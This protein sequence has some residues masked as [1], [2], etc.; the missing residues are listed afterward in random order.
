MK[1]SSSPLSRYPVALRTKIFE[2]TKD[3]KFK[4]A[5]KPYYWTTSEDNR[6]IEFADAHGKPHAAQ[7]D[8]PKHSDLATIYRELQDDLMRTYDSIN[9][10]RVASKRCSLSS[11]L[12]TQKRVRWQV[13]PAQPVEARTAE[14]GQ[15]R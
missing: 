14:E 1:E 7:K 6:L 9:T 12:C 11:W 15:R 8:L 13:L 4:D 2:A 3:S 5:A 10:R